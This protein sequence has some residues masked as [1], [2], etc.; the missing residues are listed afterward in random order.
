MQKI[1]N[2]KERN[3]VPVPFR[4]GTK[5]LFWVPVPPVP[6]RERKYSFP[7]PCPSLVLGAPNLIRKNTRKSFTCIFSKNEG[8]PHNHE[9][10]TIRMV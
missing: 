2:G 8:H 7:V 9:V 4:S 10:K 3:S 5:F 1:G 6:E